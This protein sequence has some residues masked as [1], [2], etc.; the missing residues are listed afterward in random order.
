M[1]S[2]NRVHHHGTV[3]TLLAAF[4]FMQ[5]LPTQAQSPPKK[6]NGGLQAQIVSV[7]R[8][9]TFNHLTVSITL[10]NQGKNTIYL[11]LVRGTGTPKAVDNMGADFGY[12]SSSGIAV[13][14][15]FEATPWCIG[16]PD[17]KNG[18]TPPLQ[19]WTAL[20][21]DTSPI[22]LNFALFVNRESHGHLAS[23][24][25]TLASRVVSDPAR[26]DTLTDSER[27]EH[28]HMINISLPPT[29]VNQEQ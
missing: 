14:P 16:K 24:S 18:Q 22:T 29:P 11:L 6:F 13:C 5:A 15:L 2:L 23:F 27:R 9:K 4:L 25:C 19:A 28:I 17:I 21:P 3:A 8:D 20:D 10:A 12:E 1:G 7:G 26:D